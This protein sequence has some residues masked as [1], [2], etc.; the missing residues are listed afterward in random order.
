MELKDNLIR[1]RKAKGLSQI[2]VAERLGISRQAI[3]RWET[4]FSTPSTE[5][6]RNLAK[7]YDVSVDELLGLDKASLPRETPD[8]EQSDAPFVRLTNRRRRI[9]FAAAV[10]LLIAVVFAFFAMRTRV[11]PEEDAVPVGNLDVKPW[12]SDSASRFPLEW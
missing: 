11:V 1:M 7:L 3:S 9:Y 5:N 6:L 10:L 4:G 12:D 2:A 8:A